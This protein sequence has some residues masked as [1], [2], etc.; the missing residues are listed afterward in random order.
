MSSSSCRFCVQVFLKKLKKAMA[1]KEPA[2]AERL[3]DH[4]PV[5]NLDHIVKERFVDK[6][7]CTIHDV[8][9]L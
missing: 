9:T 2:T 3:K 4:Q 1:K 5:I 8:E 6:D 7:W